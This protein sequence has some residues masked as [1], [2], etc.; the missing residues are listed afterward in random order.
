MKKLGKKNHRSHETVEAFACF[1]VVCSDAA[2]GA[3]Q[4]GWLYGGES[5][6]MYTNTKKQ[7]VN[8]ERQAGAA[9]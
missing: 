5:A 3:C 7:I 2:C 1:C 6:S 9:A 4:C 8:N